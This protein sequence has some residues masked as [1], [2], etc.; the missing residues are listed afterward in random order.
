MTHRPIPEQ[1]RLRLGITNNIVRLSLGIE[2]PQD[3]AK[4][5]T[6]AL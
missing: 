4:D 2:D 5:L 1:D 3:L 6:D